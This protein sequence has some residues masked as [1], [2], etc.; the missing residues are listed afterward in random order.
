MAKDTTS[1]KNVFTDILLIEDISKAG[2]PYKAVDLELPS[3][4]TVRV[5][6]SRAEMELVEQH[7][8]KSKI[9]VKSS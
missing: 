1:I 2:N 6:L 4:Y 7:T 8:E 9:D 5:F 3:G